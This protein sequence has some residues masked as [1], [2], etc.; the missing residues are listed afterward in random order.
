MKPEV[1]RFVDEIDWA[2]VA[3]DLAVR[4]EERL[5]R[6]GSVGSGLPAVYL[7]SDG[8]GVVSAPHEHETWAIIAGIFGREVNEFFTR[9]S[10]ATRTVSRSESEVI[11]PGDVLA[12]DRT[13]IHATSVE[14]DRPTFHL[15]VYGRP[16]DGL[17]SFADRTFVS[18]Q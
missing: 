13:A 14:G 10:S 15:H 16:L 4:G 5:Y 6:L 18:G 9:K 11:G 3:F 7:V 12:M 8:V 1:A 2:A 17:S